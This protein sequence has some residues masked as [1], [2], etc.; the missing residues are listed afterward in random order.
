M[1]T[2]A[3]IIF[4][5]TVAST[6][7]FAQQH[8]IV[9]DND[10]RIVKNYG[11]DRDDEH[12]FN[13]SFMIENVSPRDSLSYFLIYQW[14]NDYLYQANNTLDNEPPVQ[15][16][17]FDPQGYLTITVSPNRPIEDNSLLSYQL[18]KVNDTGRA[19]LD[20]GLKGVRS[21]N[22]LTY[23]YLRFI[24]ANSIFEEVTDEH[25]AT[26][27]VLKAGLIASETALAEFERIKKEEVYRDATYQAMQNQ[28]LLV[29]K[30]L[31]IRTQQME[32]VA[33]QDKECCTADAL[34]KVTLEIL[35]LTKESEDLRISM[36]LV[37][38]QLDKLIKDKRKDRDSFAAQLQQMLTSQLKEDYKHLTAPLFKILHQGVLV[39]KNENTSEVVY[40]ILAKKIFNSG[41]EEY[42]VARLTPDLPQ[43]T[44][45]SELYLH[46]I[47]LKTS[48][49]ADNPF[50]MSLSGH[51]TKGTDI[52]GASNIKA[53]ESIDTGMFEGFPDASALPK[54]QDDGSGQKGGFQQPSDIGKVEIKEYTP[55]WMNMKADYLKEEIKSNSDSIEAL[56]KQKEDLEQ[57]LTNTNDTTETYRVLKD[58]LGQL[59]GRILKF[60]EKKKNAEAKV[61]YLA[62]MASELPFKKALGKTIDE[63]LKKNGTPNYIDY[64]LKYPV[65]FEALKRPV[66]ELKALQLEVDSF[67]QKV[68]AGE[69]GKESYTLKYSDKVVTTDTLPTVHR[70]YRFSI[71][72]GLAG[73]QSVSY[74]YQRV[75]V[76][77]TVVDRLQE[78]REVSFRVRPL[79]TLSTYL[80]KPQDIAVCDKQTINTLHFDIGLD[81]LRKN[82]LDDVYLGLGV[83]PWR[84]INVAFGAKIATVSKVDRAKLDPVSLDTSAAMTSVT[85]A[86][87]YFSV[88]LGFNIIPLAINSLLTK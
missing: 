64:L 63:L 25:I 74:N 53:L 19:L 59:E 32:K 30:Q 33:S 78:S 57:H 13:Y 18:V 60:A 45:A 73:S 36:E 2:L 5:L 14:R 29:D 24:K 65:P 47:N 86:G 69:L 28:K 51:M 76:P 17:Q 50:F 8:L 67:E 16:T 70:L 37:T 10:G 40:D 23:E 79:L 48:F 41:K 54:R 85:Q 83:E 56:E 1:K 68:A 42:I 35:R 39:I 21:L 77:N 62:R 81:Y 38:E 11:F 80:I 82:V 61:N 55:E 72:T 3:L 7:T 27:D 6:A 34:D 58:K 71:N 44:T 9:F 66:I 4:S 84:N 43:L 26:F 88:N 22:R 12:N 52:E 49:L 87:F 20:G 46:T 15:I 75:P 31:A